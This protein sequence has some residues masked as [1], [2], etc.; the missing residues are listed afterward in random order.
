[1]SRNLRAFVVLTAL[2]VLSLSAVSILIT[3]QPVANAS[4]QPARELEQ[5][6]ALKQQTVP[7]TYLWNYSIKFVCGFQPQQPSPGQTPYE[8]VVKPG[9][10]ATDINI[11]NYNYREV[12]VRKKVI[13]LVEGDKV[14]REPETA[15][16][17]KSDQ[18]VLRPD[19][20]TMDD[21]LRIWQLLHPGVV[22]PAVPPL[23]IGY[24]VILS[25]LDLDVDAVYTAEVPG[26]PNTQQTG[27][28]EDVERIAGKR[29][30]VPAGALP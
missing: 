8:P 5:N 26:G 14:L 21:C 13:V 22:P 9:N 17:A 30:F 24:L 1:M 7:G 19:F 27:I 10:Y 12:A 20:A 28:S 2:L 29:V 3:R 6:N 16:P 25:P 11:H 23:L 4:T 15:G 18:I